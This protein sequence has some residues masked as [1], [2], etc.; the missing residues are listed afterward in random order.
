MDKNKPHH[1]KE[2]IKIGK[3]TKFGSVS[4]RSKYKLCRPSNLILTHFTCALPSDKLLNAKDP[5][6]LRRRHNRGQTHSTKNLNSPA[7]Q[8]GTVL[9]G[10]F[11]ISSSHRKSQIH[12][13]P[14]FPGAINFKSHCLSE[15]GAGYTLIG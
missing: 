3:F 7:N 14:F 5:P 9:G 4:L 13:N 10:S 2:D 1:Q 11:E 8:N 12:P 6:F 15:L